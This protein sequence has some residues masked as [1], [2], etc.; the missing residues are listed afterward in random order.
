LLL[1]TANKSKIDRHPQSGI[2]GAKK[3]EKQEKQ[4]KEGRI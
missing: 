2:G 1:E 4:E 3:Q